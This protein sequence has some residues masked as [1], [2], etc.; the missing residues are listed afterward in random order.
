MI[1]SHRIPRRALIAT[2]IVVLSC[3]ALL[4]ADD[5]PRPHDG[6]GIHPTDP[7]WG[8]AGQPYLR[9]V[10]ARYDDGR[11]DP[12]GRARVKMPM[13]REVSNAV[14]RQAAPRSN[15]ARASDTLWVWGQ[16]LDHDIT[17]TPLA[18]PAEVFDL[19]IP[20]GD[21]VFDPAGTGN[22]LLPF[23]RSAWW[24]GTGTSR[25][26]PRQQ[27]N[28][29]TAFIDASQVYG[30]DPARA[31]ALRSNDGTG[32][33]ETSRGRML[34]FNRAGLDN[35]GGT[36]RDLYLAGDV[37]ANEQ[38]LLLAMHTLFVREHN[39][40]AKQLRRQGGQRTDEE[41]YQEAREYV[42]ALIQAITYQEFLPL[43]LGEG[44]IP[45]YGGF[46][47]QVN[48]TIA[49][50]FATAAFRVGHT[51]VSPVLLRR[52]ADGRPIAEGDLPLTMAFFA[53][54]QVNATMG[55]EPY[56]RGMTLQAAQE[57]D[58]WVIDELRN[59]LFGPPGSGGAD[60]PAI[61]IQRGRDHGLG[62][63]NDARRAYGLPPARRFEQ[64]SSDGAVARELEAMY[65]S[66]D[67]IDVWIGGLAEDH[68]PGSMVGPLFQAIL[69][70]QFTR[71]RDGDPN[72]FERIYS[73]SR[74][75][76]IRQTRLADV[77]RRNTRI[78]RTIGADVFRVDR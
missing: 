30:S 78:N 29:I 21:P 44:A 43:L 56:L 59:L 74:L 1:A 55:I 48:P 61:N 27:I 49:N 53:P 75:R 68:V 22:V 38:S 34:P 39:R 16:F 76:K 41:I 63:Y 18:Q 46:R 51:M 69:V 31:L 66:P 8:A 36:G 58:T 42:A 65:R 12:P 2:C 15:A 7:A 54:G 50:V 10:P 47:P 17:H 35:G 67:D 3:P 40:V 23:E 4:G 72:W 71:L 20:A 14:V 45:P 9:I 60:L 28:A 57:I 5:A 33:L 70:D 52:E 73:G 26:N 77:I 62:G 32:M 64:V 37:R 11:A 6:F 24:P 25:D 13:A 19:P